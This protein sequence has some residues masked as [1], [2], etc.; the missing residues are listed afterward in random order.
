MIPRD[1]FQLLE[2]SEYIAKNESF[3]LKVEHTF[4]FVQRC[5]ECHILYWEKHKASIL[6]DDPF[7]NKQRGS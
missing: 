1:K 3:K 2:L 4:N 7:R 5:P 6:R